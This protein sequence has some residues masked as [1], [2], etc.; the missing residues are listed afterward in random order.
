M[1][2]F[3]GQERFMF[4]RWG[5]VMNENVNNKKF[6]NDYVTYW[7]TRVADT[8]NGRE[9]KDITTSDDILRMNF[10]ML[11]VNA[12][13]LFLDY[14]CGTC[15]TF[16]KYIEKCKEG[17][18]YFGVDISDA[19]L[20]KAKKKYSNLCGNNL[21]STDGEMIPFDD[22]TFDKVFCY[23]VL[24]C[25]NQEQTI[26]ELVRVCR[27]DG[28]IWITGKNYHY[29]D[30]DLL[31]YEAEVKARNNMF[32]NHFTKL[33]ELQNQLRANSV[34]LVKTLFFCRRGDASRFLYSEK[35]QERFYEWAMMIRK[36]TKQKISLYNIAEEHSQNS[37]EKKEQ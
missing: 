8:N 22:N 26:S 29:C 25:C 11:N 24:D 6:W 12:E 17:K 3:T 13:D 19:A 10:E 37:I 34:E 23:G 35:V 36:K 31:A 21:C 7:E 4:R 5:I 15:R 30:D 14:G 16:E 1:P 32:P 9:K 28:L 20:N 2:H 33:K 18:N 27:I